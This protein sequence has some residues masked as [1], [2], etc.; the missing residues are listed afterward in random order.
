MS[1]VPTKFFE[2]TP[3][4][5]E[6]HCLDFSAAAISFQ[7]NVV[8]KVSPGHRNSN[9]FG[10]CA[11]VTNIPYKND[12]FH[13]ITDKGTMDSLM[14]D[15]EKG[16]QNSQEMLSEIERTL[17]KGG[18]FLQVTDEDPDS[19]MLYLET[20]GSKTINWQFSIL[21]DTEQD[22]K[23]IFIYSFTKQVPEDKV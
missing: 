5:V 16:V 21:A 15:R 19:R 23:E 9:I 7:L 22:N 8:G 1:V 2:W 17:C 18:T 11:D 12:T 20:N 6:V 14:K 4:P 13:L 10:V 3:F